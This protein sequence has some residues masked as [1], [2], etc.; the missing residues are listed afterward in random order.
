MNEM[1]DQL[2]WRGTAVSF[3]P[4][5][6]IA[7]ALRHSGIHDFGPAIGGLRLRYFCGIGAC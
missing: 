2:H 3:R 5:E 6:T 4:G 7:A 1:R